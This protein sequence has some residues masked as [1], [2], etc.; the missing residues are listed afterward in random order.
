NNGTLING[1]R[2]AAHVS[3]SLLDGDQIKIGGVALTLVFIAER[4]YDRLLVTRWVFIFSFAALGGGFCFRPSFV[5]GGGLGLWL[6]GVVLSMIGAS[7]LISAVTWSLLWRK[8]LWSLRTSLIYFGLVLFSS[9]VLAAM[10]AWWAEPDLPL[11]R[12]I[13]DA[14]LDRFCVQR[15]V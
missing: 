12:W 7:C 8:R 11:R 1:H 6:L 15:F 2:T 10:G 4:S 3:S 9:V 14:K 13:D 5:F